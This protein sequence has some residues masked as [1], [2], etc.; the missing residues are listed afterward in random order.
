MQRT[1]APKFARSDNY[2]SLKCPQCKE[3]W[4][5]QTRAHVA[6]RDDEDGPGTV[7]ECACGVSAARRS[8]TLPGRRDSLRITFQCEQ[9]DGDMVLMIMQHKGQT[10]FYWEHPVAAAPLANAI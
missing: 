2:L 1:E 10:L 3:A 4:L 9:C 6:F 5:H 8:N 7:T